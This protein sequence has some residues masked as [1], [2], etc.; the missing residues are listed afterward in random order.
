MKMHAYISILFRLH[1]YRMFR[2]MESHCLQ[3]FQA[4]FFLISHFLAGSVSMYAIKFPKR[5]TFYLCETS[6]HL[7]DIYIRVLVGLRLKFKINSRLKK[8]DC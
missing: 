5:E 4:D 2:Q 8:Q 6:D 7:L 3:W 1:R